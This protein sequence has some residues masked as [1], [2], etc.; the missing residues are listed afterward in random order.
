[1]PEM[2]KWNDEQLR[3]ACAIS[4]SLAQICRALGIAR[5]NTA[6]VKERMAALELSLLPRIPPIN[7]SDGSNR[8]SREL[9]CDHCGNSYT[10]DEGPAHIARVKHHYCSPLC[11]QHHSSITHGMSRTHIYTMWASAKKRSKERGYAFAL[12]V[13][14]MPAIPE[15]CPVLGIPICPRSS[16]IYGP[17]DGSPSLDRIIPALGYVPSNVRIISNRAN[18]LRADG[19]AAE[20]QLVAEDATRLEEKTKPTKG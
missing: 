2:R 18:R 3:V 12:E 13:K 7:K 1:M 8:I 9:V 14:D 5:Q 4:V 17:V 6:K 10:S 16:G 20:L 15:K 11:S 19:T